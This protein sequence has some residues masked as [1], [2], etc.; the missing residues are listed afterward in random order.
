MKIYLQI[1]T[2]KLADIEPPGLPSLESVSLEYLLPK[3][4]E[5]KHLYSK[6]VS[7]IIPRLTLKVH[8]DLEMCYLLWDKFSPKETL[9]DLWDFR[10]AW[11]KGH[12]F[13][14]YFYTLYEGTRALGTL[15]LWY[16]D[17]EKTYEWIGGYW[18]EGNHFFVEDN[19]IID[20]LLSAVPIPIV[21]MSIESQ[22]KEKV[23]FARGDFKPE[24]DLKYTKNISSV[25]SIDD[26]LADCKKKD[27]YHM[28]YDYRKIAAQN[29]SV[30]MI[31]DS[32]LIEELFSLNIK[33]FSDPVFT[34]KSV[35]HDKRQTDSF[36]EVLKNAG[37]YSYK[38]VKASIGG[39]TAALDL[40]LQYNGMYYQ[41]TGGNDVRSFSGIGNFMVYTEIVDAIRHNAQVIDC[42]QEDHSWKHRYFDGREM[43]VFEK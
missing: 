10:Y 16:N 8:S 43:F 36:R 20:L 18:M 5:N 3:T 28:K 11:L 17:I 30:E 19:Y 42:L 34:E 15:P 27:R 40:I 2:M 21:L 37:V 41:M 7:R 22:D 32:A 38:F 29:P 39:K 14:Q 24:E 12:G 4:A 9:F 35:Y 33:R 6:G 13:K 31:T 1:N 23:R 26:I 25:R